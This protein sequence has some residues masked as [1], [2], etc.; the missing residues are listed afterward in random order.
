[1]G[2]RGKGAWF[3]RL[4]KNERGIIFPFAIVLLFIVTGAAL[5]YTNA[6]FAQL[7]TYNSLES[8]YVRATIN[9]L[10]TFND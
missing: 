1:M 3:Y 7:K 2:R 10:S 8:I 5:L 6:Y 4:L 9:I